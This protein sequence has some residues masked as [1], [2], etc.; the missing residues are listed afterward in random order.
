M[1]QA[2]SKWFTRFQPN[3][4]AKLRLFCFPYAG[5]GASIYRQWSSGLPAQVEVNAIK[6]PGRESRFSDPAFDQLETL[7]DALG[8][9]LEPY[10][11]KPFAFFGHSMGA[12]IAFELTRRLR[13]QRRPLPL[14]LFISGR[15]GPIVPAR[16][17]PM[18]ELPDDAFLEELKRRYGDANNALD[19]PELV[20]LILP[21]IRAD[22][23]LC[24]RYAYSPQA[25]LDI[26][27][28]AFGGVNDNMITQQDIEAWR[29]M[30]HEPFQFHMIDGDHFFLDSAR[31]ELLEL[32]SQKLEPLLAQL[33]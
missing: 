29:S 33:A 8:P 16:E 28:S 18:Y 9:V 19:N 17:E 11:D 32:L 5:G 13:E 23:T 10:L 25:T 27:I 6:L 21:L 30:T 2:S 24:D 4:Q 31:P 26:P 12:M 14:H 1:A 7:L 15:R 20:P 22:C 3:P